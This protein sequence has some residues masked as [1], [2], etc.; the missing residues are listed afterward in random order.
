M[1]EIMRER[2]IRACEAL[3]WSWQ[4]LGLSVGVRS[5]TVRR[6]ANGKNEIPE[7]L[8]VWTEKLADFHRGNPPPEKPPVE[9]WH[10]EVGG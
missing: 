3:C 7:S 10:R 4:A 1:S 8:V 2:L 9:S 5:S 6:W